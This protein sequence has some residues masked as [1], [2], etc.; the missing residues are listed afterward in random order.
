MPKSA[1]K[2]QE[3]GAKKPY[4]IATMA[5]LVA[6]LF[7]FGYFHNR[8]AQDKQKAKEDLDPQLQS[9][10]SLATQLDTTER[11]LRGDRAAA[12][13]LAD[14]LEDRSYWAA[15]LNELRHVMMRTE[16]AGKAANK[17]E[18][19]IWIERFEPD[20][21]GTA[22]AANIPIAPPTVNPPPGGRDRGMRGGPGGGGPGGGR[23]GPGGRGFRSAEGAPPGSVC[24]T[25]NIVCRGVDLTHVNANANTAFAFLLDKELKANAMFATN[26]GILATSLPDETAFPAK[27]FT[28]QAVVTLKRPLKL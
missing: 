7:A 13:E 9:L 8:I 27:T 4:L 21:A 15:V 2:G 6:I 23:F 14:W 24:S 3:F 20:C 28:I 16:A 26:S 10:Q 12:Q 5:C 18:V 19:G 25:I 1:L 22:P 11:K 17:T